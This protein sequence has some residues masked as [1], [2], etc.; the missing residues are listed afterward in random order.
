M[1][2]LSFQDHQSKINPGPA[3]WP[4]CLLVKGRVFDN[5]TRWRSAC[6]SLDGLLDYDEEDKEEGAFEINLFAENFSEMLS[7]DYGQAI[8]GALYANRCDNPTNDKWAI[9]AMMTGIWQ[10]IKVVSA[11]E[12]TDSL[13]TCLSIHH[14]A[15]RA[16]SQQMNVSKCVS[17][18]D[19][20]VPKMVFEPSLEY[21]VILPWQGSP[22]EAER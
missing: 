2:S 22:P 17:D 20:L 4:P 12:N 19:N 15:C 18:L 11:N 6:I 8:L 21:L 1:T 3:P 13:L 5:G 7:R 14:Q 16:E 10:K 9:L